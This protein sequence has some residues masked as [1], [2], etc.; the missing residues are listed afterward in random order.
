MEDI[1]VPST[2][3]QTATNIIASKYFRKKGVPNTEHEVSA[4]QVVERVVNGIRIYGENKGYFASKEDADIFQSELSYLLINQRAAFNSPV[5]FNVGLKEAYGISGGKSGNWAWDDNEGKVIEMQDAYSRPQSSACFIQYVEDDLV[6]DDRGLME[7]QKSEVKLFKYGSGTGTNFSNIR[8][9]GEPLSGGGT[10]SGLMPFLMGLNAWA[11]ATKSGGTTRR[12]A[13]MVILNYDHPEI[14]EFVTWKA[15]GEEM[16]ND[17]IN[18]GKYSK[19][20]E[21]KVYAFAPGQNSNNS[22][23]VDN[24]FMEGIHDDEAFFETTNRTDGTVRKRI[25][26]KD[27]WDLIGQSAWRSADPGLQFHDNINDWNPCSNSGEIRGSN[28]CS[29]YMF[30][31]DTACNLL[32]INV[33]PFWKNGI[34]DI[35][36]FF[37]M[38]QFFPMAYFK[39]GV[40]KKEC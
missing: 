11:G 2:W 21:G 14:E 37:K 7:L 17:L 29:E 18:T 40:Y 33:L 3:S 24:K 5:W 26:Y 10:S 9:K 8:G 6:S 38:V 28:P 27:L 39:Q 4:R 32:S 35:K 36:G 19:D 23:R 13:K 12:A 22:V 15:E 34:F 1:E 30:L 20:Y 16:V 31:D 25:R